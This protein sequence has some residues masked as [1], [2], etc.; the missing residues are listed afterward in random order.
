MLVI[1]TIAFYA[2]WLL[3][4]LASQTAFKWNIR[5][6]RTD[7]FHLIPVWTFF[8]P[9]PGVSDYNLL[10]RIRLSNG[11]LTC[12]TPIPLRS[13]K[14][15]GMALFN[16]NRRLQKALHDHAQ[17]ITM[18]VAGGQLNEENKDNIQLTFNYISILNYCAK[19]P[20]VAGSSSLQFMILESFGYHE[21]QEPQLI[22]NSGF[23]KLSMS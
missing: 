11:D 22:L 4:T 5:I 12:F 15:I 9:N 19:L 1:L 23:H 13:R 20:S 8:A 2:A 16:P 6:F 21:L 14:N 7:I 18:Q 17:T 10:L 3:L